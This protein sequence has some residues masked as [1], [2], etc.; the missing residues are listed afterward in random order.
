MSVEISMPAN[1]IAAFDTFKSL[2]RPVLQAGFDD[3]E[4][5]GSGFFRLDAI[6]VTRLTADLR[7]AQIFDI[8]F[9][10]ETAIDGLIGFLRQAEIH[11]HQVWNRIAAGRAAG[12]SESQLRN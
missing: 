3:F 4:T 12:I 9:A 8:V 2:R 11:L 1:R 7:A 5:L 6:A 10:H